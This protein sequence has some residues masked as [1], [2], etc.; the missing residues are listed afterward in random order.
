MW[1]ITLRNI[2]FRRRQFLIAVVGT[3]LVFGMALLVTGIRQ[4][5]ETEADRML[6]AMG[7]DQWVIRAGASG[8][9][10]GF[11][12][13]VARLADDLARA[14]GVRE[15]D[16]V[17]LFPQTVGEG[18]HART[19][20]VVGHRKGGFGD[21]SLVAGRPATAEG[22]AVV[23]KKLH[24]RI[25]ERFAMSGRKFRV[26]GLVEGRTYFAGTP[27][28]FLR[29][30]DAQALL[31]GG[32]LATSIIMEGSPTVTVPGLKVLPLSAVKAD[33]LKPVRQAEQSINKVRLLLWL[34]AAIIVG[35]VMY[36]SALERVRDFAVL[37]AVGASSRVLV[38]S[39]A[40]EAVIACLVSAAL[41]I[42]VARL[43]RPIIPLPVS[44]SGSAYAVLPVVA[45]IVGVL[46]S[47]SGVRR[48]V[49][50]DPAAA[51]AGA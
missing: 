24:L 35:A 1:N 37:K 28:A 34:V 50:T 12:P 51:F 20:N 16:P 48:A 6:G 2:Q 13:V 44:Y 42:G 31:G 11:A 8:P 19:V 25:G 47:L 32:P 41:A 23:D 14:P 22:D 36:M 10:T 40:I 38:T 21:P 46:S 7:G 29:L 3:A 39:L 30:E 15:A 33:L 26:V 27:T 17:I 45:V 9:F 4:G 43:L 18:V 49:N 5:F